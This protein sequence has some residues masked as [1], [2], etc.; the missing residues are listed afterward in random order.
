M[1]EEELQAIE[2]RAARATPGPWQRGEEH[3]N[4]VQVW[5]GQQLLFILHDSQFYCG[6]QEANRDFVVHARQ[7]V[8]ELSAEVRRLQAS[9]QRLLS[10]GVK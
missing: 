5:V 4:M 1:T 2:E 3:E 6:E 7:D 8:A 10:T 9:V